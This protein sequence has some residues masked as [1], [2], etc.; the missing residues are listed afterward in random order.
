MESQVAELLD[1]I[2]AMTPAGNALGLHVRFAAP[3]Y[4]FR[5]YSP[6]WSDHYSAQGLVMRDPTVA[7]GMTETGTTRWSDLHALD[8][9][10][11]LKEA[12]SFGLAYGLTVSVLDGGSRSVGGFARSDR[13]FSD[14]EIGALWRAVARLHAITTKG[15]PLSP[16]DQKTIKALSVTV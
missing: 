7:W 4:L 3:T 12:A 11:V 9:A 16:G 2:G 5:T 14:D 15:T 13:E 8:T 1:R 6:E 10:G